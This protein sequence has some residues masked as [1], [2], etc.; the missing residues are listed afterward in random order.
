MP[1]VQELLALPLAAILMCSF[2]SQYMYILSLHSYVSRALPGMMLASY[3]GVEEG[4]EKKYLVCT[5]RTC[6]YQCMYV[7]I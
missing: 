5:V 7:Y 6:A 1:E 3:P 2:P 4:E